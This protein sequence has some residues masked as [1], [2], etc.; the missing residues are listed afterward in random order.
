MAESKSDTEQLLALVATGDEAATQT[1]LQR[2]RRRLVAM[3][4][5]RMD[6]RLAARFDPSDVVQDALAEAAKRL[7]QYARQ[8]P[9]PFYPWLRSM[10]WEK[11]IQ[12][13]RQHLH[14][15]RRTVQREE[16]FFPLSQESELLLVDRIANSTL[17][18]SRQVLQRE[19]CGRVRIAL[20]ELPEVSR[21]I[22]I[23][24]HL[25]ELPFKEIA[26]ILAVSETAV[27]SRYRRAVENL[28][29]ILAREM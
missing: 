11:L 16:A 8:Q 2:H 9:M 26:T 24:R 12:L 15:K 4:G 22:V 27:Y 28:S 25:E 20:Q 1:L 17:G 10:A 3:V 13:Q 19:I 29:R 7:P 5:L 6:G 18:A 23:L 14:A 21:E